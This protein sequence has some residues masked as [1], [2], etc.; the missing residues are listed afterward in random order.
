MCIRDRCD[1]E[2]DNMEVTVNCYCSV[3]PLFSLGNLAILL[4]AVI[5]GS[6]RAHTHTLTPIWWKISEHLCSDIQIYIKF[7]QPLSYFYFT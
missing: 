6:A 2:G 1:R 7:I 5:Y 4:S 3:S